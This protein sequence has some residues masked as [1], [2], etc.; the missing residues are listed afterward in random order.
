MK[1]RLTVTLDPVVVRKAKA[2]ALS[3]DTNFS[4]LIETLLRLDIANEGRVSFTKKWAGKLTA[5]SGRDE[6]T[7]ALLGKYE[8]ISR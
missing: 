6:R 3:R 1:E 2:L 7:R 4:A 5:R 8:R